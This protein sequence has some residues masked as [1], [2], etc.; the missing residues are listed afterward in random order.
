MTIFETLW[1][2]I[3]NN[4]SHNA[5]AIISV[6]N[7]PKKIDRK[8]M[9]LTLTRSN[10]DGTQLLAVLDY[11]VPIPPKNAIY[12]LQ[13]QVKKISFLEE[14]QQVMMIHRHEFESC[15]SQMPITFL[16]FSA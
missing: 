16:T 15:K 1:V 7:A 13:T 11:R 9:K 2:E 6:K 5:T 12:I 14:N 10:L 8:K 4:K 3:N